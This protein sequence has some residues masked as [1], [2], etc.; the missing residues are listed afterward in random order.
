MHGSSV[1]SVRCAVDSVCV[2][3]GETVREEKLL[4]LRKHGAGKGP[5]RSDDKIERWDGEAGHGEKS[6]PHRALCIH[7]PNV[8]EIKHPANANVSYHTRILYM[9][10]KP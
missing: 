7:L 10:V 9:F 3:R 5:A 6:D 2:W 1:G 4:C 8:V